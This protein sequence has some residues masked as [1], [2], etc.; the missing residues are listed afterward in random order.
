M[1]QLKTVYE[2]FTL[3]EWKLINKALHSYWMNH[4]E[5]PT[6]KLIEICTKL[7]SASWDK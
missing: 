5:M 2:Y 1:E 3:E 7:P 4:K 6:Q